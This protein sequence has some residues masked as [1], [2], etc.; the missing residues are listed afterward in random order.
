MARPAS[1]WR[2]GDAAVGSSVI[3]FLVAGVLFMASVVAVLVATRSGSDSQATDDAPDA[4]AFQVQARGLADLLLGSPGYAGGLEFAAGVSSVDHTGKLADADLVTRLGLLDPDSTD[5]NMMDFV[6]FQNLRLAPQQDDLADGPAN[7]DYVNY[8]EAA[9]TLGLGTSMDFHIRSYPSLASAA[10][11]VSAA[12]LRDSNLRVAYVADSVAASTVVANPAAGLNLGELTCRVDESA[13]PGALII[14]SDLTMDSSGTPTAFEAVF[15]FEFSNQDKESRKRNTGI[16]PDDGSTVAIAIQPGAIGD[17]ECSGLKATLKLY[18]TDNLLLTRTTPSGGFP[19]F[20]PD[21]PDP[22]PD[23]ALRLDASSM[24]YLDSQDVVLDW[25]LS[26]DLEENDQLYLTVCPNPTPECPGTGPGELLLDID[27]PKK[28]NDR[29]PWTIPAATLGPGT[30]TARLYLDS[31]ATTSYRA[32]QT[33]LITSAVVAPAVGPYVSVEPPPGEAVAIEVGFLEDLMGKFCPTWYNSNDETEDQPLDPSEWTVPTGDSQ[34]WADRCSSF[35]TGQPHDGDVYPQK[36]LKSTLEARL[37]KSVADGG[38]LSTSAGSCR[39]APT[40]EYTNVLVIGSNVD[41]NKMTSGDVKDCIQDWVLGGGTLI[42]LGS[43][44]GK[45]EWLQSTFK[46]A[47]EGSSTGINVPDSAHP[48]LHVPNELGWPAYQHSYAWR[49]KETGKFDSE[50]AFTRVVNEATSDPNAILAVSDPGD[51]QGGSVILTGW[52]PFD[53]NGAA[54]GQLLDEGRNLLHNLLML[55]Y[56]DLYLDYGPALPA[57]SNVIPAV[58]GAQICHPEFDE[59]ATADVCENP[60][61]LRLLVYVF[62]SS[63]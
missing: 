44:E 59:A 29:V 6:K 60:I 30:Y 39:Y 35:K 53:V 51:F 22:R 8:E 24:A 14:S 49:L 5:S 46:V 37:T 2:Q 48:V 52:T 56:R 55:G 16:V 36:S 31:V 28:Q 40:Y 47:L 61:D 38:T 1:P 4:A 26:K 58:R 32:T 19:A 62:P 45:T 21:S 34:T 3:A 43:A 57:F 27:V 54:S 20:D 41:H 9:A 15:D 11:M 50:A 10:E 33:V 18:D 7:D 12:H 25:T 17:R 23:R 13:A 63:G 42:V